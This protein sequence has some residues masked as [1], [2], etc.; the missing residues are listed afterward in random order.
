[1][2]RTPDQIHI[3]TPPQINTLARLLNCFYYCGGHPIG[4]P[5]G[6]PDKVRP[7]TSEGHPESLCRPIEVRSSDRA[8][9]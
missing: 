5:K 4:H 1:M 2:G 9:S 7:R 8:S 3:R 6:H